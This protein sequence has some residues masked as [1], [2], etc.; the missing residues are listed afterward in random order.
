MASTMLIPTAITSAI[1]RSSRSLPAM[2]VGRRLISAPQVVADGD[3]VLESVTAARVRRLRVDRQVDADLR[4]SPRGRGRER[5]DGVRGDVVGP[6]HRAGRVT[7]CAGL[8]IDLVAGSRPHRT[9][10]RGVRAG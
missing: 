6:A 3:R 4:E 10:R 9:P 8:P 7:G 2:L 1:P 5:E